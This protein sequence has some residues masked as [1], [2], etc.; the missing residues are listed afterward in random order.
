MPGVPLGRTGAQ[1]G[2]GQS[3]MTARKVAGVFFLFTPHLMGMAAAL[4]GVVAVSALVAALCIGAATI[5][6]SSGAYPLLS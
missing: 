2:K 3:S 6:M 5:S 4:L 1:P